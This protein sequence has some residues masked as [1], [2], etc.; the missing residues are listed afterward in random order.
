MNVFLF[1][2]QGSQEIGMAADLFK[3]DPCFRDL[4]AF[5]AGKSG[6][7]L[8]RIC[9]R[10]PER[11][12]IRTR[13]LQPL[14]VCVSLGYLRHLTERGVRSDCVLGHSL[15]EVT[16]LAAA[17][18]ISAEAAVALAA[19]RGRLMDGAAAQVAGGMVAVTT[20]NRERL[21]QWLATMPPERLVLA[22]DNAP[23]QLVLSGT[24]AALEEVGRFVA[25][26]RLGACRK[27]PVAGP[28]HSPLMAE[29]QRAF[30]GW[31]QAIPFRA[32][33]TPVVFNITGNQEDDPARIRSLA[34]RNLAEPVRWRTSME[35]VR[36]MRPTTLFEIG[37]GRVLAGLA[38]ANGFDDATRIVHVNNLR[39]VE[40]AVAAKNPVDVGGPNRSSSSSSTPPV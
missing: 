34:A 27:L 39:G 33:A 17:G 8:E 15:G 12:L 40:L 1:P 30:T 26:E 13:N 38:R 28:W 35:T 19:E 16:A 11:E 37:P 24:V 14:L 2:G 5:A 3:A 29:A 21:V 25:A 10:G 23:T 32:P 36:T 20:P 22:N 31:L 6:A 4:V 7:D 18:V 9:L